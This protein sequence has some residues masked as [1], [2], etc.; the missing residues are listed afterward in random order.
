MNNEARRGERPAPELTPF[1]ETLKTE[2][3]RAVAAWLG[4]SSE[5]TIRWQDSEAGEGIGRLVNR[6]EVFERRLEITLQDA[7]PEAER[8]RDGIEIRWRALDHLGPDED[9][10]LQQWVA[11]L[12]EL[13]SEAAASDGSSA[14]LRAA[15]E[16]VQGFA[17]AG[18]ED[19]TLRRVEPTGVG[20]LGVLR[21]GYRCNQDC[22]VCFQG[23]DWPEPPRQLLLQWLDEMAQAG[24]QLLMLTGGEPTVYPWLG[25]LIQRAASAHQME[26]HLQTNAV[27]FAKQDY[28]RRLVDAGLSSASIAFHAADPARSDEF[29]RAPGTHQ[30]TVAGIRNALD[31]DLVVLLCCC[32]DDGT[33]DG[34]EEH[35]RFI[36]EQFVTPYAD[37]PVR[38][39]EYLQPGGYHDRARMQ[40]TLS[41]L[42]RVEPL[43]VAA[44]RILRAAGVGL[45]CTGPCGFPQCVFRN[46]PSLVPWRERQQLFPD[47]VYWRGFEETCGRCAA[48][49]HCMGLREEYV[50]IHGTRGVVPYDALPEVEEV[51]DELGEILRARR[52][53][54]QRART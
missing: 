6:A 8:Q 46:E 41:S 37:N 40:R 34:L 52:R 45:E 23:R 11:K 24:I 38:R 39:V 28:L 25:E 53:A 26:V 18:I 50:A 51:P 21:L 4:L 48:A 22:A 32:V 5:V 44:G 7:T 2:A 42:D 43:L 13:T 54:K 1:V 12:D 16:A 27:L 9:E 30:L 29:C 47:G 35:A 49:S 17:L 10:A 20:K 33:L 19:R 14:E 36:V 15:L 3:A 31:A